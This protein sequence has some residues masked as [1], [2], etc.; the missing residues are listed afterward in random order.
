[1]TRPEGRGVVAEATDP[2]ARFRTLPDRIRLE[3]TFVPVPTE[4]RTPGRDTY[5]HDEWL[6]RNL[7]CG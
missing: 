4:A 7:W 3:D 5:S 6:A 2:R 1:M